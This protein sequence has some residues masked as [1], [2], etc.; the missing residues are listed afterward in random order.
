M[1]KLQKEIS[2]FLSGRILTK[3]ELGD[4]AEFIESDDF[5]DSVEKS[6]GMKELSSSKIICNR[7]GTKHLKNDVALPNGS[8]YCPE[9][10]NMRRV[11]SDEF[12]YHQK[13]LSFKC[14][15]ALNW[16]GQLTDLQAKISKQLV[17]SFRKKQSILVHAV[18]GAGKTEMIYQVINE[19]LKSGGR[20]G[21]A[22][23][24]IDVCIELHL[25]LTRDFKLDIA[26]LH[27]EGEAYFP[28]QLVIAT[29][30]QL[31]RFKE[32]FD[33]LII[34]EV[35]AF[36]FA[37]NKMLYFAAENARKVESCLI[38]LTATSSP[39]LEKE[40]TSGRLNRLSLARRFHAKP[41]VV[42]RMFWQ[43]NFHSQIKKQ[44]KTTFPLLIFAPEIEK[45]ENLAE[46][47][48]KLY[49]NEKVAFV[50]SETENRLE[51]V[52]A[53]RNQE[54]SMLVSTTILERGVTFP[55]VDV[56]IYHAEHFNFTTSALI[57][58]AGRAGRS[59]ERPTGLVY[60]FHEGQTKAMQRSI[61]E[62]RQMNKLGGFV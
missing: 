6:A 57:Q 2:D 37:D 61:K 15:D 4:L 5:I 35:D 39:L 44:R 55:K 31:L 22:T 42:P 9:C 23:P 62:I 19:A 33:L 24:R 1:E 14:L 10:I 29:T 28:S 32:A 47:L 54:I 17:E 27:A 46:E 16:Q 50:S 30:H 26:L 34:D 8:F 53:F 20:V 43:T 3:A 49:P 58:I 56:F 48:Q 38:Y 51:I 52:K 18:T 41:L 21:I 13:Q 45:G 25:R 11:R 59:P 60:Y 36:P 7:C 12:L 40:I